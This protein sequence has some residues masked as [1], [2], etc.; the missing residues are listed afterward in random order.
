MAPFK[1]ADDDTAQ[2]Y[3]EQDSVQ[4]PPD[5]GCTDS[6]KRVECRAWQVVEAGSTETG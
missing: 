2:R 6:T 1:I 4:Q 5:S 3:V